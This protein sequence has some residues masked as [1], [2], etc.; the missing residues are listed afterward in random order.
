MYALSRTPDTPTADEWTEGVNAA[1]SDVI[2]QPRLA[3][4]RPP[5]IEILIRRG[6]EVTTRL[7]EAMPTTLSSLLQRAAIDAAGSP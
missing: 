2:Y 1:H 5:N 4:R 6:L 3:R 7:P